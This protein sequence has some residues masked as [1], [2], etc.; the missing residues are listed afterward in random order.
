MHVLVR[1]G[2]SNDDVGVAK[3]TVFQEIRPWVGF[4]TGDYIREKLRALHHRMTRV[5]F[6]PNQFWGLRRTCLNL[7]KRG[8]SEKKWRTSIVGFVD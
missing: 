3:G 5:Q 2:L 7:R 8:A 6:C 1:E 4:K